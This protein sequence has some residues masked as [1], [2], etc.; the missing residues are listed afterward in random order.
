MGLRSDRSD[1]AEGLRPDACLV[2]SRLGFVGQ[3]VRRE[4][5]DGGWRSCGRQK[6]AAFPVGMRKQEGERW[7]KS[8]CALLGEGV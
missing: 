6:I 5:R 2:I 8:G 4:N 7:R 3:R 1:E